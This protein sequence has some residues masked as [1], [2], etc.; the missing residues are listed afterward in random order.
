MAYAYMQRKEMG[1][2]RADTQDIVPNM[3]VKD[4]CNAESY[5]AP[6]KAP[7]AVTF[8]EQLGNVEYVA[9]IPSS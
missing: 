9:K 4:D 2:N 3:I 5:V 8:G 7:N 1:K 6:V